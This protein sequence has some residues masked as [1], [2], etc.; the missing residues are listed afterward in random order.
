MVTNKLAAVNP[1]LLS[2][3][4][5]DRCGFRWSS[6]LSWSGFLGLWSLFFL[7]HWTW[8]ALGD[9]FALDDTLFDEHVMDT[10][11]WL[12]TLADPVED[13]VLLENRHFGVRIVATEHLHMAMTWGL[14]LFL[15]DDPELGL[16]SLAETVEADDEHNF[17]KKA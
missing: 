10:I 13:T 15:K 14:G 8:H 11:G 17:P 6:C 9:D 7:L 2:L 5:L 3:W 16:V 4:S 12:G 1:L